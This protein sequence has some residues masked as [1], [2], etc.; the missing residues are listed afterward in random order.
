MTIFQ[1]KF[2]QAPIKRL[3]PSQDHFIR[4][5]FFGGRCE[6]FKPHGRNLYA[7]DVNSLYPYAMTF[8][9]PINN[10]KWHRDLRNQNLINI[11]E[12]YIGFIKAEIIAPNDMYIPVLPLRS[13]VSGKTIFPVGKWTGTYFSEELAYAEQMGYIIKPLCGYL[14]DRDST[15]P[16]KKF[17]DTLYDMRKQASIEKNTTLKTI[18]KLILNTLY[19]KLAFA[20]NKNRSYLVN[21]NDIENFIESKEIVGVEQTP[22]MENFSKV[23]L[24]YIPCRL[25]RSPISIGCLCRSYY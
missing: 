11:L 3:K 4:P 16:F 17:V 22:E 9:M 14:F 2:Y 15:Y 12:N 19:G 8:P 24:P 7:Y 18:I 10:I 6:I 1:S 21:N 25:G 20:N 5:A 23:T 13:T